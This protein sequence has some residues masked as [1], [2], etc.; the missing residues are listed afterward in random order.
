VAKNTVLMKI[1]AL[2][3]SELKMKNQVQA[4]P[5][6]QKKGFKPHAQLPS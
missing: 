4:K 3:D 1:D 6:M 2:S 5:S